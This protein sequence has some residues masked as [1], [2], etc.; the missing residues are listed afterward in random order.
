MVTISPIGLSAAPVAGRLDLL[1][2][3][4]EKLCRA[5]CTDSTLQPQV[6]IVYTSGTARLNDITI[7]VPITATITIVTPG[8]G[9]KATTQLFT[10]KFVAAFRGYSTLPT[11]VTIAQNGRLQEL[12]CLN[13]GKARA[14]TLYDSLSITI[15]GATA[16]TPPAA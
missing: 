7:F 6:S 16:V 9:C 15:T 3:Y 14:V 1:A 10:E 13:C 11:A 5:I 12:S 4:R 2:T 8:C